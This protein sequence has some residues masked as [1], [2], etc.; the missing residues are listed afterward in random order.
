M[1]HMVEIRK[2]NIDENINKQLRKAL[3]LLHEDSLQAWKATQATKDKQEE[4]NIACVMQGNE[5]WK[6][7]REDQENTWNCWSCQV[8]EISWPIT[9]NNAEEKQKVTKK[10]IADN[11]AHEVKGL[12]RIKRKNFDKTRKGKVQVNLTLNLTTSGTKR[13]KNALMGVK[14]TN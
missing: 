13:E 12:M 7:K 4:Q 2:F 5:T 3:S 6:Q 11:E 8:V 14:F 10:H 1:K 9:H